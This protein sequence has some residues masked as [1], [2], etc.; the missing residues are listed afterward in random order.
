M[1]RYTGKM[2]EL[3]AGRGNQC[4]ING[5]LVRDKLQ[6]AHIK[7]TG[8][9]GEGR[10]RSNRYYDIKNNPE[11]YKLMCKWHHHKFDREYWKNQVSI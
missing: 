4:E 5:C 11:C 7:P 8:L 3:R 6:F 2:D 10:G 9:S 1:S